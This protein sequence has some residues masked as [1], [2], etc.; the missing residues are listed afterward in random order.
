M[1]KS[2][3]KLRFEKSKVSALNSQLA[4]IRGGAN[5]NLRGIETK[6]MCT[7]QT[8]CYCTTAYEIS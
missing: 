2:I 4:R 5:Y 3:N 8:D 7:N 1:K 6:Q